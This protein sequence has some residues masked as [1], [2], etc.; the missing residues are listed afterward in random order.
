MAIM[1]CVDVY[2]VPGGRRS[3]G[4]AGSA[5]SGPG[6]APPPTSSARSSASS[7]RPSIWPRT[8]ARPCAPPAAC[9]RIE[10]A[11]SCEEPE[12]SSPPLFCPSA[13]PCRLPGAAPVPPFPTLPCESL[14]GGGEVDPLPAVPVAPPQPVAPVVCP[15]GPA[16]PAGPAA[17]AAPHP[18][19][20]RLFERARRPDICDFH[21]SRMSAGRSAPPPRPVLLVRL[22]PLP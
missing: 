7:R 21:C 6:P 15:A 19:A 4:R 16:G 1:Y 17:A 3:G 2:Y 12:V 9:R 13:R 22:V 11:S 20:V 5:G 14:E 10:C 18:L 8:W